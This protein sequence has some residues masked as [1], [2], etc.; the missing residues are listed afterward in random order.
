MFASRQFVRLFSTSQPGL[1]NQTYHHPSQHPHRRPPHS[2]STPGT[3]AA[4]WTPH[5]ME[6]LVGDD[7]GSGY[8]PPDFALLLYKTWIQRN[9]HACYLWGRSQCQIFTCKNTC[10]QETENKELK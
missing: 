6:L 4:L 9:Q 10:L 7:S 5:L 3:R 8:H 2:S 1:N